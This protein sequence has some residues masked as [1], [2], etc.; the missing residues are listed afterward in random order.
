MRKPD[1]AAKEKRESAW[2]K[3]EK[4][5][6]NK[7]EAAKTERYLAGEKRKAGKVCYD[8]EGE[9]NGIKD[10]GNG[11]AAVPMDDVVQHGGNGVDKSWLPRAGV[12][13]DLHQRESCAGDDNRGGLGRK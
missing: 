5:I 6:V 13:A 2:S 8:W 12:L 3:L 4:K 9:K 10:Y 11:G 1:K 7:L